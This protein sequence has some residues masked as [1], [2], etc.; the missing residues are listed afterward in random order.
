[1]DKKEFAKVV[2][3]LQTYYPKED[4]L[5]ANN[6]AIELWY[7]QLQDIPYEVMQ[8]AVVKWVSTEKWSPTIAELRSI[9]AEI[10]NGTTEDW[11]EAW[12]K[13]CAAIGA[14]GYNRPI[15]AIKSLPPLAGKTVERLGWINLCRSENMQADRANFRLIYEQLATETKKQHQIPQKFLEKIKYLEAGND[16]DC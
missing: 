16:N 11:G 6:Y 5:L 10:M 3:A 7:R 9:A 15:E 4:K 12:Q 2:M 13:V 8:A 14:Y 1:M